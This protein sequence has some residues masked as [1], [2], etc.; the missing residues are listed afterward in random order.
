MT[1]TVP[2]ARVRTGYRIELAADALDWVI[3]G[4]DEAAYRDAA[5]GEIVII[6]IATAS[7]LSRK[8]LSP[9]VKYERYPDTS[10]ISA[11]AVF[12][13]ERHDCTPEEALARICR[14]VKIPASDGISE[15]IAA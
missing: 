1:D 2:T 7:E 13:S 8:T 6:R 9:V 5:T 11:I 4:E 12:A 3:Q 15:A 14:I 10:T